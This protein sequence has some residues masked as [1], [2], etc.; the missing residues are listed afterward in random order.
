[1]PTREARSGNGN[2]LGIL[3]LRTF[4][5]KSKIVGGTLTLVKGVAQQT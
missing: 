2:C 5:E 3:Y 4:I 1:M